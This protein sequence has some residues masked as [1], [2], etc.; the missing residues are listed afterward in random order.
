M[1][2]V[3]TLTVNLTPCS[4]AVFWYLTQIKLPPASLAQ[5]K[6]W[7]EQ[8][9]PLIFCSVIKPSFWV[10][11]FNPFTSNPHFCWLPDIVSPKS[12]DFIERSPHQYY[13]QLFCLIFF[14]FLKAIL[15]NRLHQ[16]FALLNNCQPLYI[17][18]CCMLYNSLSLV[19]LT[20]SQKE[21][22][23]ELKPAPRDDGNFKE[24]L[25]SLVSTSR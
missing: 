10:I 15:Y 3:V 6:S 14:W 9:I 8:H 5:R 20:L 7:I 22:W 4:Q 12:L 13:L 24:I 17:S 21:G 19:A 11:N 2:G 1:L 16:T 18:T 25:L 23:R